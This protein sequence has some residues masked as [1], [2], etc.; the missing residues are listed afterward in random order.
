MSSPSSQE[1]E[2]V[3]LY[4]K[5]DLQGVIKN[6]ELGGGTLDY[7]GSGPYVIIINERREAGESESERCDGHRLD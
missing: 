3:T 2:Y 1:T 5:R 6:L 7:P 4:G